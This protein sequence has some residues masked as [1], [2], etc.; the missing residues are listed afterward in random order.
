MILTW[1]HVELKQY[2]WWYQWRKIKPKISQTQ[3]TG[4]SPEGTHLSLT[5]L[6]G[7]RAVVWL[8][9]CWA[10]SKI[11]SELS[12]VLNLYKNTIS[13]NHAIIYLHPGLLWTILPGARSFKKHPLSPAPYQKPDSSGTLSSNLSFFFSLECNKENRPKKN[14]AELFCD[15][16]C[17]WRKDSK[18]HAKGRE[19]ATNQWGTNC[20]EFRLK[21][22][23]S[24]AKARNGSAT[25]VHRHRIN[26][27]IRAFF[28]AFS[29]APLS[30]LAV[31]LALVK[32][33]SVKQQ[34]ISR[35]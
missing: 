22:S 29:L 7:V 30:K 21:H 26:D 25:A 32:A 12:T 28:A 20:A 8:I 13:A 14:A 31:S 23:A 27:H 16:S 33:A 17:G 5:S 11:T 18:R 4:T 19:E 34:H 10:K 2:C 1:C 35:T 9:M 6:S 3:R 24:S 15:S